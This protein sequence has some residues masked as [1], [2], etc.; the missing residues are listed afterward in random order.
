M[1]HFCLTFCLNLCYQ[2]VS[3]Q[4][5]AYHRRAYGTKM[6]CAHCF[7]FS[8]HACVSSDTS[9]YVLNAFPCSSC[10][11]CAF[12]SKIAGCQRNNHRFEDA[13][14]TPTPLLQ[15]S[16]VIH[17]FSDLTSKSFPTPATP[18]PTTPT[19]TPTP[20][21]PSSILQAP[22]QTKLE[23]QAKPQPCFAIIIEDLSATS[24]SLLCFRSYMN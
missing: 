19:A 18:T 6:H 9:E 1:A 12:S 3:L 8:S 13:E 11:D 17:R 15:A 4:L 16:I 20:T 14:D 21:I 24:G 23:S 7:Y 2:N 5:I 22:I 10:S